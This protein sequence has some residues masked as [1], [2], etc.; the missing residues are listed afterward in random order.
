M[1]VP[2]TAFGP[3]SPRYTFGAVQ[4]FAWDDELSDAAGVRGAAG[5]GGMTGFERQI[6][7]KLPLRLDPARLPRPTRTKSIAMTGADKAPTQQ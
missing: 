4:Q 1:I 2:G 5:V 7:W 6:V 3:L